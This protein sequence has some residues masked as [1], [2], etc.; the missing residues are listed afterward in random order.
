M[1]RIVVIYNGKGGAGKT[2]T[3]V[4]LAY[5]LSALGKKVLLIDAD[6]QGSASFHLLGAKYEYQEVTL[7]D[8]ITEQKYVPPIQINEH[9]FL[10]PAHSGLAKAE[11]DLPKEITK[12]YQYR[13]KKLLKA[14]YQQFE[15]ILIDTPGSHISIFTIMAL[16]AGD[17]VLVPAKPEASHRQATLESMSLIE[18]IQDDLNPDLQVF[19]ILVTQY[20]NSTHHKELSQMLGEIKDPRGN[21]YPLY[22]YPSLNRVRYNDATVSNVPVY[23]FADTATLR[24]YWTRMSQDIVRGSF[25]LEETCEVQV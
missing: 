2:P 14:H 21:F 22:P 4:H 10:L 24:A 25:S 11:D 5:S 9:L 20:Q 1:S 17:T 8:A 23:E 6:Q 19:A 3:V 16:V 12:P 13:M 7:Y 18:D 15:Y